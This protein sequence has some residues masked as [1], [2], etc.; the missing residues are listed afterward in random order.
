MD[1]TKLR[2]LLE[3]LEQA[4]CRHE[5]AQEWKSVDAGVETSLALEVAREKVISFV[6]EAV[7]KR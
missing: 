4:A 1:E 3:D 6:R 2:E 5:W 7:E